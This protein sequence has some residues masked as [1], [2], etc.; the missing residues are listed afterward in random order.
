MLSSEI[1]VTPYI[2]TITVTAYIDTIYTCVPLDL[3]WISMYGDCL[4]MR[5]TWLLVDAIWWRNT[6]ILLSC[7]LSRIYREN[8]VL[9][10]EYYIWLTCIGFMLYEWHCRQRCF[11][12]L[13][14]DS[15]RPP[16]SCGCPC[17]CRATA[18]GRGPGYGPGQKWWGDA[19]SIW[20]SAFVLEWLG[21]AW[22]LGW[23]L[24]SYG[25]L[26]RS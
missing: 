4:K 24:E 26:N 8:L 7:A 1:A 9:M 6:M 20:G 23:S 15:Q 16:R 21:L 12:V 19:L 5:G 25:V 22:R 17:G 11:L 2:D 18:P 3:S 10:N 14:C 13:A